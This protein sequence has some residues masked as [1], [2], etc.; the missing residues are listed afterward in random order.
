VKP[1]SEACERNRG[2]I[3]D[4]L[5][6]VFSDCR[7]V[8]E[9]GSGSG[10]HAAYFGAE[11]PHL[12][13]Q[14]SDLPAAHAGIRL[15]LAEAR[16]PNVLPPLAL[17][18]IADAWP[19][20]RYDGV[21]SANTLH[22]VSWAA[23]ERMFAGIARVLPVHGVLAVYGPFNYSGRFTADS[24]AAFDQWLRQRD[25]ASGIRD[26]ESVD[27]LARSRGF[28]LMHDFAMPANNRT[29]VWRRLS[30]NAG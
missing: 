16:L 22:I 11:L 19:Q 13:W 20:E 5:K 6:Q 7:S 9:I 17:D 29:L 21:F 12:T 14:T 10:Q 25:A 15:W 27:S 24:N 30:E 8:L 28:A 4:I 3:L 2:P 1:F 23:A 26:F 18:V